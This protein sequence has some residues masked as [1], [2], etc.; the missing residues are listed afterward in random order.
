MNANCIKLN[1]TR[2]NWLF[3]AAL[4][5]TGI[6]LPAKSQAALIFGNLNVSG[7]VN[8]SLGKIDFP[9]G[10]GPGVGGPVIEGSST[11]GFALVPGLAG[12][13]GTVLDIDTPPYNPP[14]PAS[15][16]TPLW[17][18]FPALTVSGVSFTMQVLNAGVQPTPCPVGTPLAGQ[19]C[20]PGPPLSPFNLANT[21]TSSSTASFT[22]SGV[23]TDGTNTNPFF[24]VFTAQFPDM[25]LQ[26]LN[27]SIAAGGTINTTYSASIIVAPIPEPASAVTLAGG[28]LFLAIAL[29]LR[30]RVQEQG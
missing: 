23:E 26:A 20:T 17:L 13:T 22:V 9:P 28:L 16:T 10:I 4:G 7:V 1:G 3:V 11:G 27:A 29:F 19:S 21:S 15:F 6:L 18:T 24:G 30:K 25:S 8:V 2:I 5:V 14:L 12:S